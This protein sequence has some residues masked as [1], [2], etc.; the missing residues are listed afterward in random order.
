MA[1][2]VDDAHLPPQVKEELWFRVRVTNIGKVAGDEV[3]L[4]FVR[5]N[6]TTLGPLKQLFGFK[7][8]VA[9]LPGAPPLQHET[10]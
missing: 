4:A 3:V 10:V 7:R 9:M 8:L 6:E 5:R 2:S 1:D